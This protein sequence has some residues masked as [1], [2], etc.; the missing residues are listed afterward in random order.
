MKKM[1][2]LA[3]IL[4]ACLTGG[5]LN[6]QVPS[7]ATD[8][9]PMLVGE[10]APDA[11]LVGADG[12]AIQLYSLTASKPTVIIFYRGDWCSN[13]TSHFKDEINPHI[14]EIE[15][16]GYN[17]IAVSPDGPTALKKTST[18]S[19]MDAKYFYGDGSMA[20]VKALGLAWKQQERMYENLTRASDGKNTEYLLSVPA[21][22]VIGTDNVIQLAHI[23]PNAIRATARV[24]WT[25]LGSMLKGL[26]G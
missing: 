2:F 23:S 24:K 3:A 15:A 14:A 7:V 5:Q 22:Y 19:G 20:F 12:N 10:T 6:A 16:M 8:I 26:K 4:L 21:V 1:I 13:C 18:D 11:T 17:L 9:S 25:L